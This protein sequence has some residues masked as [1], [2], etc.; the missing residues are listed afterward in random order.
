MAELLVKLEEA[1]NPSDLNA[2]GKGHV[3]CVKE[4]GWAWGKAECPPKF[5]VIH[6]D[7]MTVAEAMKYME[8]ET[9]TSTLD[10]PLA[11][12]EPAL[13]GETKAEPERI[14]PVAIR[15]LKIDLEH[16]SLSEQ[17]VADLK[18][19]KIVLL[20]KAQIEPCEKTYATSVIEAE[21][22]IAAKAEAEARV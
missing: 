4:D 1:D 16:T 19:Q 17:E 15:K 14:I 12:G 10:K 22:Y 2:W 21:A 3:V 20:T 13:E 6:I 11:E 8:P 5:S 18:T 9:T 7:D